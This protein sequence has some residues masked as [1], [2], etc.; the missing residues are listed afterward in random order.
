M[1]YTKFGEFKKSWGFGNVTIS[2]LNCSS[3]SNVITLSSPATLS[4]LSLFNTKTFTRNE[5]GSLKYN[6]LFSLF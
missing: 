1:I 2:P 6:Y 3:F 4:S 5:L